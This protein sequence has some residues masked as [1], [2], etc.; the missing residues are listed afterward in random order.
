MLEGRMVI[1]LGLRD[2]YY[3]QEL[4][5]GSSK[6]LKKDVVP[7]KQSRVMEVEVSYVVKPR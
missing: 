5:C 2:L 1:D 4:D 3:N 6:K 7:E